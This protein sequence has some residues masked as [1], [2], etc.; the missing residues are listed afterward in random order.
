MRH[1]SAT[2]PP[3]V[4]APRAEPG[5]AATPARLRERRAFGFLA[6][7][8]LLVVVRLAMPV[9]VGLFLG[10]VLAFVL[11]PINTRLR[12]RKMKAGTAALVCA[13]GATAVV[14]S[15]VIGVT[16]LIVTRGISFLAV[17]REQL[18]PGGP[19]R[20]FAEVAMNRLSAL[21][22]NSDDLSQRLES[23][24]GELAS[25][26]AG[27]AAQI[28]GITF[29]GFLTLLF[30]AL[31]TH[32]VLHYWSDIVARAEHMLP[33][34]QR[35]THALLE[36]FRMVGRE[37]LLGTVVTGLAQ[38]LL[39]GLGYWITGVPEPAFFGALTALASL[40]PGVGTLL[41]WIPIGIV[42]ILTGHTGAG[43]AEIIYAALTVGIISDYVI[44]PRLVGGQ[45]NVPSVLMFIALFGGV[46]VF[47]VIGLIVGPIL[48]TLCLA[49][50]KTYERQ[51]AG[52]APS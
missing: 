39:A 10:V 31:A 9:G 13:L 50:L 8:A 35:H 7:G 5:E 32:F 48:V 26:A 34:E 15:T 4:S 22:V 46:E 20:V 11:E 14:A 19:L 17:L 3:S 18:A 36:Q 42:R 43:L 29:S 52:R 23:E 40:I 38:G 2:E 12:K 51:V 1:P 33:F 28:A 45:K 27:F 25:R 6:L 44:R 30:M 24:A 41:V 37:V 16:T 47:G 49:V 21:H